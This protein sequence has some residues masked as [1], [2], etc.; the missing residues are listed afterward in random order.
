MSVYQIKKKQ[1]SKLDNLI[2]KNV[3]IIIIKNFLQKNFCKE[4]IEYCV[5]ISQ[6]NQH[7]KLT[8]EGDYFSTDIDILKPTK[9]AFFAL[10]PKVNKNG[11]SKYSYKNPSVINKCYYMDQ[12]IIKGLKFTVQHMNIIDFKI[13]ENFYMFANKH[14]R[15]NASADNSYYIPFSLY[16]EEAQPS[17]NVNFS[18]IKGKNI[19]I[20]LYKEFIE[21]Y[22]NS[23]INKNL[24]NIE[25]IFINRSY[26]LLKF[27]KG[28]GCLIFY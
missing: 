18:M 11:L 2:K 19:Q 17:G 15:L 13:G 4:I 1:F 22:F 21:T 25:L 7:R 27:E 26:N 5:N 8:K 16:P 23:D 28:K 12:K 10:I 20:N 6:K 14:S 24:Q 9:D 3:P